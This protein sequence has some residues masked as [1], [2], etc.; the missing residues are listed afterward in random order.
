MSRCRIVVAVA[1]L[2]LAACS[3]D[4]APT[5]SAPTD[6]DTS[7]VPTVEDAAGDTAPDE[8]STVSEPEAT[9]PQ[10]IDPQATEAP[11]DETAPEPTTT[12]DDGGGGG[13]EAATTTTTTTSPLVIDGPAEVVDASNV[14]SSTET[15]EYDFSE[16]SPIVDDFLAESGLNGVGLIVVE[17]DD[18]VV[19][20]DHWGEFDEDRV[21]L[22]ASSSKMITA[23]VLL[24]LDDQDII[25]IDAPVAEYVDWGS[26]NPDVTVAQLLSNSSGLVGLGPNPLYAPYLCQFTGT[27][28]EECGQEVFTTDADDGDVIAPDT[29]FRYGGAQWQVGGAVAEAATGKTWDE[30]VDEIYV[31][32]CGLD[33]LG[34]N[35]HFAQ[36]PIPDEFGYPTGFDGDVSALNETDNPSMEG[37]VYSDT[38]DYG[39]LLLMHLRGGMC[40]DNAVLSQDALDTMHSDRIAEAYDGDAGGP[41]TGYGM[42]WWIDRDTGL[43][44]DPGL[45]GAHPWLDLE[46][47]YGAYMVIEANGAL[48]G[49]LVEQLRDPIDSAV[50]SAR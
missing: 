19:Y 44:S 3:S 4:D 1:V 47:G 9:D 38:G 24:H 5:D 18:G 48:S 13:D 17:R 8:T 50:L 49:Q 12:A 42:G 11:V 25:D 16:I 28:I 31:Q 32:P 22:I 37:G 26:G 34:Y 30:L 15:R 46:D 6:A 29:E 14:E 27:E 41:D 23:G 7:S 2:T 21:S 39:E 45:Y 10:A 33:V 40:D 20:E 43:I 35:N 36:L